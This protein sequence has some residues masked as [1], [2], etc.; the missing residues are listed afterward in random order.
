MLPILT[1]LH[2]HRIHW[3]K[4]LLFA[5]AFLTLSHA[6]V[7]LAQQA[8]T[9]EDI[10]A[11]VPTAPPGFKPISLPTTPLRYETGEGMAVEVK[12]IAQGLSHPWSMSVLPGGDI[13]VTERNNGNLRLIHNS[14]LDPNPIAGIPTVVSFSYSGLHAVV[15]DPDFKNNKLIYLTYVKPLG[16]DVVTLAV[17]RGTWDDKKKAIVNGKD[18][19]Q[20]GPGNASASSLMFDKDGFMWI[21]QYAGGPESQDLSKI[22]GK[23]LRLTRDGKPAPNNPFAKKENVRPEIYTYGHRTTQ[24]FAQHPQT[25]DIWSVEMGPNG[26]DKINILKPGANYGWPEVNL[27]RDYAGPW[28][29][30]FEKEGIERPVIYWMPSISVSGMLFYTGDKLPKWKGDLFV[31]GLRTGEI[32][33]TGLLQR[34]KLNG[35]GEE[36]RR[37]TLLADLHHRIRGAFQD[38]AG[39]LYVLT[40][41]D[42]GAVLRFEAVE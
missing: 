26:G 29:G 2:T 20:A 12:V 16:D 37:E 17:Y 11:R 23:T 40:D 24:G 28:Q 15:Q 38:E 22:S 32:P 5:I 18:I 31:G 41:E 33:G 3:K 8:E 36:I 14:S 39:Y 4:K 30:K 27:G 6:N 21:S 7:L 42:N 1:H 25:G 19:F 10:L 35:N 34:I 13:L 9:L